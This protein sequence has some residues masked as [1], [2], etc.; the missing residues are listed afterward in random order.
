MSWAR[1]REGG[2]GLVEAFFGLSL[3]FGG[4]NLDLDLD[5]LGGWLGSGWDK[6]I[7][8]GN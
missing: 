3:D 8:I 6:W 1:G 4:I 7:W 5:L 2:G